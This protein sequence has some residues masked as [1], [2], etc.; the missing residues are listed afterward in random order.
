MDSPPWHLTSLC[1]VGRSVFLLVVFCHVVDAA[2]LHRWIRGGG[3]A[4]LAAADRVFAE[5]AFFASGPE[6]GDPGSTRD[7][8]AAATDQDGG[9]G[10]TGRGGDEG[11]GRWQASSLR[12]SVSN[13]TVYAAPPA[14]T[15][16]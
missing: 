9:D 15:L 16:T 1:S 14:G 11:R 7:S 4:A 3:A 6:A 12:S 13:I 8:E 5:Y 2:C 10:N